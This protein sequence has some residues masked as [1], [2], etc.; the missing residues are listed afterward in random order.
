LVSSWL[1]NWLLALPFQ[2]SPGLLMLDPL[3]VG[4][5]LW[6]LLLL[7]SASSSPSGQVS[8]GGSV[9]SFFRSAVS[10]FSS[11]S[12]FVWLRLLLLLLLLSW[13]LLLLLL[14]PLLLYDERRR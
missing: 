4:G 13:G 7:R 8:R 2:A 11:G 6:L 9:P 3:T 5:Q 10:A 12:S 1:L 14:L